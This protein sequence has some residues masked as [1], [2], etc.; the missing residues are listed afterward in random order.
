MANYN[1]YSV[2]KELDVTNL[3]NKWFAEVQTTHYRDSKTMEYTSSKDFIFLE[4]LLKPEGINVYLD[5]SNDNYGISD[6]NI[7]VC[8]EELDKYLLDEIKELVG[9]NKRIGTILIV[10][11]IVG[12]RYLINLVGYG[13][14]SQKMTNVVWVDSIRFPMEI[15]NIANTGVFNYRTVTIPDDIVKLIHDNKPDEIDA[16]STIYDVFLN[17]VIVRSN[18]CADHLCGYDRDN[19]KKIVFNVE[20]LE[21]D[22]DGIQLVVYIT[23]IM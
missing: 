14:E 19:A 1:S 12:D 8:F 10:P 6:L 18:Y 3:Y 21:D 20:T 22:D 13:S 16:N 2:M 7:R 23:I 15:S 17:N 9:T 4:E 5:H 11:E